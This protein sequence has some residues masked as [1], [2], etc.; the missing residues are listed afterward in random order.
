[1]QPFS[2]HNPTR[3]VFGEGRIAALDT[4]VPA[5]AKVLILVGGSSAEKTGTL[6]E[7]RQALGS[8][9]HATFSGIEPNPTYE[10]LMKAVEQIRA[11]GWDF[12]L[13][14]GGGSVIDGVK[15]IAA[16][17]PYAGDPWE[18]LLTRAK[19]VKGAVPFGSVLTLPATGSEMNSGAVITKAA[20]QDK[21][22]FGSPHCFPVFSIL[23]PAKTLTLPPRQ[24]ANGI[25]DAFVHITEQY[26]TYPAG[27]HVQDRLSEGLLSTLVELGPRALS[28][29]ENLEVRGSLMWAATLALNG[30]IGAGVPQDWAT[31]MVGHELTALHGIDHARTL[32]L[33]LP[34][35]LEVRFEAKKAK[36]AQYGTRVFGLQGSE[37]ERA[38]GAIEATRAFFESLGVPTRLSAYGITQEGLP[39]LLAQLERHG[40]TALGEDQSQTLDHSRRILEAAL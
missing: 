23:D 32:A 7:V 11:E 20:T 39:A 34:G 24:V 3:I 4:L 19:H 27:G 14:V 30:L 9:T 38:K 13:A 25:V 22:A 17:V 8:R 21:L 29:P 18:I 31:H 2:L 40:L 37:E 35:T 36:L 28:E 12:L 10:T 16:A 5:Q 6:A 33:V 26:L 1:M 15:F